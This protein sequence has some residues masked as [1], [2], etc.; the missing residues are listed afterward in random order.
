M[1]VPVSFINKVIRD[2]SERSQEYDDFDMQDV[3]D[4]VME[5]AAGWDKTSD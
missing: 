5:E 4:A 3:K 1:N 2:V